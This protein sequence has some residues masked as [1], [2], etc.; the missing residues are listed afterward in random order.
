MIA[1]SFQTHEYRQHDVLGASPLRL[2]LL[3]YDVAIKACEQE[4]FERATQAISLLRDALDF[5]QG[6]IA[7]KLFALYQWCLECVRKDK[8]Q[9]ALQVLRALGEVWE[10]VD[11][12]NSPVARSGTSYVEVPRVAQ[13]A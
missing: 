2:I 3:T 9:D 11:R 8:Y 1:T 13:A 7:V 5:D 12:M 6:E 10:E 4:D